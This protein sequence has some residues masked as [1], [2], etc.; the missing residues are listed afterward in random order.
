MGFRKGNTMKFEGTKAEKRVLI[1]KDVLKNLKAKKLEVATGTYCTFFKGN[2]QV[3]FKVGCLQK[4][5][6]NKTNIK[7]E[8]CA[9]GSA[10]YSYIMKFNNFNVTE[11]GDEYFNETDMNVLERIFTPLQLSMIESAF[12]GCAMV[13]RINHDFDQAYNH[14]AILRSIEFGDKY[15]ND[16]PRLQSIMQNIVDNNGTFKP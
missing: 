1:A 7:C 15:Y 13:E 6:Q 11:D 16:A 3:E 14:I 2:S 9:L 5:L 4:Q 10:F 12:E 8:C